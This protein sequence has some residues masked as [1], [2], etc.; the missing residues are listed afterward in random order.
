MIANENLMMEC[1]DGKTQLFNI[2]YEEKKKQFVGNFVFFSFKGLSNK[3][4]TFIFLFPPIRR[5]SVN[6]ELNL[7]GFFLAFNAVAINTIIFTSIIQ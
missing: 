5:K 4:K 3:N 7:I 2:M 1:D 6:L